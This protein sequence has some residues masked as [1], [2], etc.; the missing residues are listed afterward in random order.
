MTLTKHTQIAQ[1]KALM[2][3]ELFHSNVS[4]SKRIVTDETKQQLTN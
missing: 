1:I 2:R 4:I 3:N